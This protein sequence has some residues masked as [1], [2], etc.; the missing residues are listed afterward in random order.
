MSGGARGVDREVHR[1]CLLKGKPTVVVVPSGL[2]QL[3]PQ[4]LEDW[5]ESIVSSG[6]C[7]V[8]EYEPDVTMK[9]HHFL[10][11]NRIVSGLS[12]VTLVVE[13]ARKSGS[14]MTGRLARDQGRTVAV[15]PG[16]PADVHRQGTVDL[17]VDGAQAIRDDLDL[18]ALLA[19]A[20][21]DQ[22]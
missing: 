5:A 4:E 2:D 1:T 3:Y 8:S 14:W 15:L 11:R 22:L 6:G 18:L 7:L 12:S 10:R 9:R 19:I 16:F 13:A 20:Y 17:L 21:P